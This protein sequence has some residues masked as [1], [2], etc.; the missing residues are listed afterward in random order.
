MNA[1]STA[2]K[3]NRIYSWRSDWNFTEQERVKLVKE[4]HSVAVFGE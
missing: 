1:H 3:P 4:F 2:L